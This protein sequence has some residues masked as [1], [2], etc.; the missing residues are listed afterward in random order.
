LPFTIFGK[1]SLIK[2][3][4]PDGE[5]KLK[6]NKYNLFSYYRW[7]KEEHK[8]WK[9]WTCNF[10]KH[11]HHFCIS[12]DQGF[13]FLVHNTIK[14]CQE[15]DFNILNINWVKCNNLDIS[16]FSALF[17]RKIVAVMTSYDMVFKTVGEEKR[18]LFLI[19]LSH[20]VVKYISI[21]HYRSLSSAFAILLTLVTQI[22]IELWADKKQ[23][24]D[25]TL[26]IAC[27]CVVL[28]VF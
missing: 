17:V 2:P 13:S 28:S 11:L 23:I 6:I 19:F 5:R 26:K 12:D 9:S 20:G 27:H 4:C 24:S 1:S 3:N 22:F 25:S 7:F 8:A 16:L 18:D 14:L 21:G 10:L 15:E